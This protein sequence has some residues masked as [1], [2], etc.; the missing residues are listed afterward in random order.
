MKTMCQSS[1]NCSQCR[2]RLLQMCRPIRPDDALLAATPQSHRQVCKLS[3]DSAPKVAWK[4]RR[5]AWNGESF[6]CLWFRVRKDKPQCLVWWRW[7]GNSCWRHKWSK[8]IPVLLLLDP[9]LHRF[10]V[11]LALSRQIHIRQCFRSFDASKGSIWRLCSKSRWRLYKWIQLVKFH[12]LFSLKKLFLSHLLWHSTVL[13]YGQ[14]G[15]GKTH[16]MMGDPSNTAED[17]LL[18]CYCTVWTHFDKSSQERGVIPRVVDNVFRQMSLAASGVEFTVN[19]R[20]SQNFS[21]LCVYFVY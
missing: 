9:Q 12:V 16:S 8:G 13:A 5:A 15:S 18:R 11:I 14:T 4:W 6:S 17:V 1:P 20:I 2:H 19:V 21:I 7:E 10:Q 3:A